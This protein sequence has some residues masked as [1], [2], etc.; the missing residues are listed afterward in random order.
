MY[1]GVLPPWTG[2][3]EGGRH[4]LEGEKN[5]HV[6]GLWW[7]I[8]KTGRS[9]SCAVL[10]VLPAAAAAAAANFG[11]AGRNSHADTPFAAGGRSSGG[12]PVGVGGCRDIRVQ[13]QEPNIKFVM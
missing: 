4:T 6:V 3:E 1:Y 13:M 2:S 7:L 10:V 11:V 5:T 9:D 12:T 8:G